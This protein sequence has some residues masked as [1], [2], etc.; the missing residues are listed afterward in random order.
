GYTRRVDAEVLSDAASGGPQHAEAV[1][2]VDHQRCVVPLAQLHDRRQVRDVAVHAE[3]SVGDHE[4]TSAADLAQ[5]PLEVG[6]VVVGVGDDPCP[7]QAV[8]VQDAGVV[9]DISDDDVV[10]ADQPSDC[11][12]VSDVAAG[13]DDGVLGAQEAGDGQLQL[14]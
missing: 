11:G 7:G 12:Y 4:S 13:E 5:C 1:R 10:G 3:H 8:A 9:V 6:H 2:F 14:P